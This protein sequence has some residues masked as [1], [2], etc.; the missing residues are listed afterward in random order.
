MGGTLVL[1]VF[2]PGHP[3]DTP[4]NEPGCPRKGRG[5]FSSP[6]TLTVREEFV[7]LLDNEIQNLIRL[8]AR[9]GD[10]LVSVVLWLVA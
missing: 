10:A 1:G 3:P 8:G 5:G 6:V 9:G 4:E 2:C 7:D